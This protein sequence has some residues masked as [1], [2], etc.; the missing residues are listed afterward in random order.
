MLNFS[1][2]QGNK[3]TSGN[4]G[5]NLPIGIKPVD[6]QKAQAPMEQLEQQGVNPNENKVGAIKDPVHE[7]EE[8]T[9]ID[10]KTGIEMTGSK[11]KSQSTTVAERN[12]KRVLFEQAIKTILVN[13][14][15]I[16]SEQ[17]DKEYETYISGD[18]DPS[19]KATDMIKKLQ[20][21]SNALPLVTNKKIESKFNPDGTPNEE[22]ARQQIQSKGYQVKTQRE[23]ED[24]EP[25]KVLDSGRRNPEWDAWNEREKEFLR[26]NPDSSES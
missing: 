2:A 8:F 26:N 6:P 11:E 1:G 5:L 24:P 3:E 23:I 12:I 9:Y 10:P 25:P 20:T 21:I 18:V 22:W 14:E 13:N 19:T 4:R 7:T 15:V 17:W 16:T